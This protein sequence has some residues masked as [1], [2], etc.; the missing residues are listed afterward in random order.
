MKNAKLPVKSFTRWLP[1]RCALAHSFLTGGL[2][3]R[4]QFFPTGVPFKSEH[5]VWMSERAG[6]RA[7]GGGA[8]V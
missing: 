5:V 4:R 1:K 6:G 7:G 8:K 2:G 3:K